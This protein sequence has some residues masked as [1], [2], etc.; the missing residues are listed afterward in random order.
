MDCVVGDVLYEGK[1]VRGR[2]CKVIYCPA[3]GYIHLHPKPSEEDLQ[4]YYR[5][6]YYG[7][8]KPDYDAEQRRQDDYLRE[9][10][11]EKVSVLRPGPGVLA[12]DVGCGRESLWVEE[13][14][15]NSDGFIGYG[16]DPSFDRPCEIVEGFYVANSW[17][18]LD[19]T[20]ERTAPGKKFDFVNLSFVL[21]HVVNPAEVLVN[22]WKRMEPHAKIC[23]EVPND[24]SGL[25]MDLWQ[26]EGAPHWVSTP[27][28][29][30]Y[31]WPKHMMR[32][33]KRCGFGNLQV[34]TTHPVEKFIS[35]GHDYRTNKEAADFLVSER[36]K[37]QKIWR[38]SGQS[39]N[40]FFG[41]TFWVVA[42]KGLMG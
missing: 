38:E 41:R 21:E 20:V 34:R 13:M 12:L 5:T 27:D 42:E 36:G 9:V 39:K 14:R 24:F 40:S 32:M 37:R 26:N 22:C 2:Q 30:N 15:L 19:A 35:E 25:Q 31:W 17:Q 6:E 11:R 33:L 16:M 7:R 4:E 8:E 28:H 3:C 29:V 1:C 10:T 23:V 18:H